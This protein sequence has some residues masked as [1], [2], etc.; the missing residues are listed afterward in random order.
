MFTLSVIYFFIT[1]TKYNMWLILVM[2]FI[3]FILSNRTNLLATNHL[4]IQEK[5]KFDTEHKSLKFLLEIMILVSFWNRIYSQG[6]VIYVH[7]EQHVS[8]A[9]PTC[10]EEVF[11][12]TFVVNGGKMLLQKPVDL[13]SI[14]MD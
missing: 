6:K 3:T 8:S 9:V 2:N 12:Q 10:N 1:N 11:W 7:Y 5:T 13:L 4:I 14:I